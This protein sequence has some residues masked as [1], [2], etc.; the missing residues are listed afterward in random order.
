MDVLGTLV[1]SVVAAR[2]VPCGSG[3]VD[4]GCDI[5]YLKD[6]VYLTPPTI[7]GGDTME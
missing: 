4:G 6:K 3:P 5:T 7:P 1:T 2:D